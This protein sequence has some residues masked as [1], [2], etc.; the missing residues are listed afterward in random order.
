MA[1]VTIKVI[2]AATNFDFLTL[3]EAKLYLGI[4]TGDTS[5]DEWLQMM[6]SINSAYIAEV[7]NRTFA[8]EEV[9]ETWREVY[10]G[11]VFLTHWP[12]KEENVQSVISAGQSAPVYELEEASGKISNVALYEAES[13]HWDKSVIVR[14]TGGYKLP[15]EAPLPLKQV[16][17]MLIREEKT[18][19]AQSAVSGIRQLSHKGARVM[20]FDVNA[21]IAKQSTSGKTGGRQLADAFL[22]QYMRIW[23]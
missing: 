3:D 18:T 21:A 19:A 16:A 5:Q 20:F 14:Y 2:T 1:D 8:E 22:R 13:Q 10:N 23:V 12:V 7:C 11:R 15:E 6:I 9:E 4:A 17:A